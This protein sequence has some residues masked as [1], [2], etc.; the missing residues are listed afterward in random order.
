MSPGRVFLIALGACTLGAQTV[1][2]ARVE[3]KPLSRTVTLTGE[4]LP[5]Q[6]V[7]L[8]ARV[9]G[10]VEQIA[11]D[12][13]SSVREG[14]LLA[15]LS[16]PEMEAQVAEAQAK[17]RAA[18]AA[19]SEAK[20]RVVAEESTYQRLKEASAT[21]GVI[22][23]NE[24]VIAEQAAEAAKGMLSSSEAALGA[25]QASLTAL[26][27]MEQ[28]LK[29]TAPFAGVITE[30]LVHPGALAGPGTGPL[31]RLEQVSRLRL[32]VA[33]PEAS[34]AGIRGGAKVSFQVSAYPTRTFTGTVA[35]IARSI[36]PK[37][38]TMAVELD[39]PNSSGMLAPGMYPQVSWP[40]TSAEKA[41]LV[42]ATSVVRTT[43]RLFVIRVSEG[44]AHWV[45]V[46]TGARDQGVV[47]VF[48]ELSEGDVVVRN[49]SDEI[50]DG[51]PITTGAPDSSS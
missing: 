43:E 18:E 5:Y 16:A 41:L 11:V 38:R 21:P 27:K 6:D 2:V 45:D 24:L 9:Q 30:R 32:V 49:G 17:V 19:V 48:G 3:A 1:E 7:D 22:A 12:R 31:V 34:F 47:Q 46:R 44:R 10:F 35:R 20:A 33:V 25:A 42:P 37:T 4:F 13:G 39:V 23:G 14:E 15:T 28:Y 50:R 26:Q 40:V 36:D 8:R 51:A 29:I